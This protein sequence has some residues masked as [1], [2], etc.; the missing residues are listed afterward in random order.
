MADNSRDHA[1]SSGGPVPAAQTG[2]TTRNSEGEIE[3]VAG[4]GMSSGRASRLPV[5]LLSFLKVFLYGTDT[6]CDAFAAF[7]GGVHCDEA[8]HDYETALDGL[9]R[10]VYTSVYRYCSGS[11]FRHR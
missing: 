6:A 2:G 11:A 9:D 3:I 10:L 5:S 4:R 8:A 1:Q 7:G